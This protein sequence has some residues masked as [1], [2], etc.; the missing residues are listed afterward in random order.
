M[1][2]KKLKVVNLAEV[3]NGV[4]KHFTLAEKWEKKYKK[5]QAVIK[6]LKAETS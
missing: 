5:W 1:I 3:I 2:K 4:Q 6:Y